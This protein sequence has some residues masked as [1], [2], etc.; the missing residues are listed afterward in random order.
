HQADVVLCPIADP[1]VSRPQCGGHFGG[2]I[3]A[4]LQS[5]TSQRLLRVWSPIADVTVRNRSG[6]T[7]VTGTISWNRVGLSSRN[8]TLSVC[9][10]G[11][12]W[13]AVVNRLGRPRLAPNW[14][15][16]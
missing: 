13:A 7:P 11:R 8:M 12:N 15:E 5:P 6:S 14:G 9:S 2:F 4:I 3:A 16:C 10:S 1:A